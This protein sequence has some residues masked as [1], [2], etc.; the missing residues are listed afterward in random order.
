MRLRTLA[1]AA[2]LAPAFA[3]A[4]PPAAPAADTTTFRI[5][6]QEGVLS[7]GMKL[8]V[9]E[10]HE[11]PTAS[12]VIKF[13]V[14]SVDERTGQTGIA[15]IL[16]HMLFKGTDVWGTRDYAKEKPLL[17]RTEELYQAILAAR[18]DL[19]LETRRNTELYDEIVRVS[20]AL[21]VA[22]AV[23][24]E[25]RDGKKVESLGKEAAPLLAAGGDAVKRV[26]DLEAEFCRV[27]EEAEQFVVEDEDWAVLDRNGAWGLNASTGD[28]STQYFYSIPA[29]RLELWA[30]IESGRMRHPVL[31]QFY[32]E[33]DVIMEERRMRTDNNPGGKVQ[34]QLHALAFTAHPYTWPTIGWAS[35]ISVVSR[36]QVEAFF[37][38]HYAPNRAVACIVG[39]VKFE[40]VKALMERYFGD[41][42]RQPDPEPV[43]TVEPRQGGERRGVV[44]FPNLRVPQVTVAYHR[45]AI[46]H[47]DFVVLDVINGILTSGNSGRLDRL[48]WEKR[49]G[50]FG[51]ANPDTLYPDVFLLFGTPLPGKTLADMEKEIAEQVRRLREEPVTDE[52]L[53]RVRNQ[54]AATL[55]RGMQ[56]NMGLAHNLTNYEVLLRWDY[57]NSYPDAVAKVTK[58]DIQRVARKYFE[59]DN[60]TVVQLLPAETAGQGAPAGR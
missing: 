4:S 36:T 54:S 8:L 31:R 14:G 49:T 37:H 39:D 38:E 51:A 60:R 28:D 12:C 22:A 24:A 43:V 27:Q 56:S 17:D 57:L 15:H 58:E 2:A 10:R 3:A 48:F 47:P 9:V 20:H 34:E 45:P 32:K 26:F 55:I 59:D 7:N 23:P 5:P 30:L 46:G 44:K 50:Q 53:L 42:P 35:D 6:V 11:A 1:A 41:I 18:R 19:P 13:R 29:N 25:R 21:A 16:E 33:R 40:Q 52:E